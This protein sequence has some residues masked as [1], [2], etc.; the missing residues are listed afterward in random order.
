MA[1]Y[2][3]PSLV[4]ISVMSPA[5]TWS[6]A[7]AVKSRRTKSGKAGRLPGRVSPLRLRIL[8]PA[9][10]SSAISFATVFTETLQPWRTSVIQTFGE[11]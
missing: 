4:T 6:G 3:L 2:S 7:S 11:P 10:P 5:H 1:R 9:R 8:R